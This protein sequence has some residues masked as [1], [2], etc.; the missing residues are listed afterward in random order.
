VRGPA[1]R[2]PSSS[3][4]YRPIRLCSTLRHLRWAAPLSPDIASGNGDICLITAPVHPQKDS[5][6]GRLTFAPVD[7][8]Q[9]EILIAELIMFHGALLLL[10]CWCQVLRKFG[11]SEA[12]CSM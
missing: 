1:A 12:G 7:T 11:I 6:T 8:A 5:I 9:S 3:S 2:R 4:G 10:L